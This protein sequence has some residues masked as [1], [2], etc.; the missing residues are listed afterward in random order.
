MV[1]R[2]RYALPLSPSL[3][4]KFDALSA[5]LDGGPVIVQAEVPILPGDS[6]TTL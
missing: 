2:S 6:E 5:E 4:Q 3:A 1:G